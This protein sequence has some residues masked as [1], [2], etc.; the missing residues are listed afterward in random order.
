VKK[1]ENYWLNKILNDEMIF[2][3]PLSINAK[4]V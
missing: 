1:I 2:R 3:G 4:N